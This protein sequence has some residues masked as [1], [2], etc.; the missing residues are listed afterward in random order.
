MGSLSSVNQQIA[1]E[2]INT[3]FS[4]VTESI[5]FEETAGYSTRNNST[6]KKEKT[7]ETE[8]ALACI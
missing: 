6:D 1:V 7:E 8:V 5:R 4:F 3:A 2:P